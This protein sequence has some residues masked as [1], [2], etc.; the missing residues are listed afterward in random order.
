MGGGKKSKKRAGRQGSG[1]QTK[2]ASD[3]EA[4]NVN[5]KNEMRTASAGDFETDGPCE[6]SVADKLNEAQILDDSTEV[7]IMSRSDNDLKNNNEYKGSSMVTLDSGY[8]DQSVSSAET[9]VQKVEG[10]FT[11]A[12]TTASSFNDSKGSTGIRDPFEV[13]FSGALN[14]NAYKS[15][16]KPKTTTS[17]GRKDREIRIG[18]PG[19][20]LKSIDDYIDLGVDPVYA[21]MKHPLENA[22]TFWYFMGDHLKQF[23]DQGR[24]ETE[25]WNMCQRNLITVDTIEDFWS[26]FNHIER[27]SRINLGCDYCFFKKGI[28]PDWADFQNKYGGRWVI[29]WKDQD[30]RFKDD[31]DSYWMEILFILIGEHGHPYNAIV[32]GAVINVRKNKFRIGVWLKGSK[33]ENAIRHIGAL[34][35]ERLGL[36]ISIPFHYHEQ[37]QNSGSKRGSKI[38]NVYR[39]IV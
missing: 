36:R 30:L 9:S 13:S 11:E 27:P 4:K 32:N 31:I 7:V 39:I 3:V 24:T 33:D 8:A 17:S 35:K 25:A 22:W 5:I 18:F 26:V 1:S 23:R 2:I 28:E 12:E 38:G 14:N 34:V 10:S 15:T 19:G 16:Y 29:E 6:D 37:E 20:D 21:T